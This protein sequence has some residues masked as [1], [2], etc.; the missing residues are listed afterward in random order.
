M[1]EGEGRKLVKGDRGGR[2]EEGGG[3]SAGQG[4]VCGGGLGVGEL[5]R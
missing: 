4:K 2:R 1:S 3:D 5:G